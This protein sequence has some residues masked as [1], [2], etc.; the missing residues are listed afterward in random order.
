MSLPSILSGIY[1]ANIYIYIPSNHL[2][3]LCPSQLPSG[4]GGGGP[5][6]GHQLMKGPQIDQTLTLSHLSHLN[7][8]LEYLDRA[9]GT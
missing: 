2:L 1:G 9:A 8:L 4:E 7:V 6:T 3:L 5:G